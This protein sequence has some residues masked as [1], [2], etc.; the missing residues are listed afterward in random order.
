MLERKEII[1]HVVT[2][3]G[4]ASLTQALATLLTQTQKLPRGPPGR[5]WRASRATTCEGEAVAIFAWGRELLPRR[6]PGYTGVGSTSEHYKKKCV[7]SQTDLIRFV[8]SKL[9]LRG[10]SRRPGRPFFLIF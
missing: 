9:V 10:A 6:L 4:F 5:E 7:R 8:S 3:E 2:F 1:E